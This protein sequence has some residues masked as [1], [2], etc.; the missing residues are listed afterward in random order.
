MALPTEHD[1]YLQTLILN[2]QTSLLRSVL[3][4]DG[5]PEQVEE[6]TPAMNAMFKPEP[7]ATVSAEIEAIF[8]GTKPASLGRAQTAVAELRDEMERINERLAPERAA[9]WKAGANI[10]S[11]AEAPLKACQEKLA[12]AR[13]NLDREC[14][15]YRPT[16]QAALRPARQKAGKL[17]AE[18]MAPIQDAI[19]LLEEINR[20]A[21]MTGIIL[22]DATASNLSHIR[23]ALREVARQCG[24]AA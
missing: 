13:Q 5:S 19:A 20:R 7:A 8:V 14:E 4:L 24:V 2:L 12:A 6:Q 1:L 15:S 17:M 16:L 21:V 23:D 11:Y 9:A 18:A 10:P 3:D 22:P